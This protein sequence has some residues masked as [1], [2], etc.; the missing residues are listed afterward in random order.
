MDRGTKKVRTRTGWK[1][2]ILIKR[3]KIGVGFTKAVAAGRQPGVGTRLTKGNVHYVGQLHGGGCHLRRRH[4]T[5]QVLGRVRRDERSTQC[6]RIDG[7]QYVHLLSSLLVIEIFI[8][9]L[10]D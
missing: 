9:L 1:R 5:R 6:C 2:S 4:G 3:W 8:F 10:V 7:T